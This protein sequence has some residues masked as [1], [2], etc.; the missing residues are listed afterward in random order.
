MKRRTR[1]S[2]RKREGGFALLLVFVMAAVIAITL[3]M[4]FPRLAFD[5]QRQKEQLLMERGQQYEIAI[6]RYMQ[7]GMRGGANIAVGSPWPAKIE[8]LENTNG[9]RFLRKRYIDP[10]TGKDEWRLIHVNAGVLTDSLNNKPAQGTKDTASSPSGIADFAGLGQTPTATSGAN[11]A[12]TRRRAS[13]SGGPGG[14]GTGDSNQPG[15]SGSSSGASGNTPGQT[16]NPAIPGDTSASGANS[17]GQPTIPGVPGAAANS[18]FPGGVSPFPQP[19]GATTGGP[20]SPANLINNLL[21]QPRNTGMPQVIGAG[22]TTIGGGIAGFASNLDADSIMVCG[23]HTNYKEWEFIFD[24]SKWRAPANPNNKALGTPIGN[25]AT[26]SAGSPSSFNMSAV[27]S[28]S[29]TNST[30]GG[31]RPNG[32]QMGATQGAFGSTCG[33]EARPGVQ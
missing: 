20:V 28:T 24:P 18:N 1:V 13:D 33:M 16:S 21:T 11:L 26:S 31:T 15:D 2:R 30:T 23:D 5:T 27:G 6:R 32:T 17:S 14:G 25:S 10:M 7:R 3:Y 22:T 9:R 29:A 19:G 12:V 8:D 4:E